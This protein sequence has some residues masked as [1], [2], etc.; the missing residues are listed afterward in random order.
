FFIAIETAY[1]LV[2]PSRFL[3]ESD[4]AAERLTWSEHC[5]VD[6]ASLM[7]VRTPV[8]LQA[9]GVREWWVQ[10]MDGRLAL[11]RVPSCE[12]SEADLPQPTLQPGGR[13]DFSLGIQFSVA[14]GAAIFERYEPST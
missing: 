1:L 6:N 14:G 8:T 3:I 9:S 13:V 4:T 12:I 11:L 2:I 7:A 10:R 5:V